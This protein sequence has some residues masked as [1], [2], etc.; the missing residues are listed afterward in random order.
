MR[1]EHCSQVGLSIYILGR[2]MILRY[3]VEVP[4]TCLHFGPTI[5]N[6]IVTGNCFTEI[7]Q[8]LVLTPYPGV[9]LSNH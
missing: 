7:K 5:T 6:R 3:A 2:D 8:T 9:S 1:R 4:Y